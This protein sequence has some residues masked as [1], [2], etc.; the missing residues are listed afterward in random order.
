[1]EVT[2]ETLE[3]LVGDIVHRTMDAVQQCVT[4][5]G[6]APDDIDQVV[7]V[8]GQTRMPLVQ[9]CVTNF[10]KKPPHKGVN[11]DEVVAMGAAIQADILAS[12]DESLLLLDVT[13]LSLGIGTF[14]GQFAS[15][16]P[17]NSTV[18]TRKSHTFTTTRDDQTAVKIRV[19]QGESTQ[20]DE[21]HLLGEFVLTEIPMAE[22]GE[23]E[24][25]VSFEIDSDGIVNVFARDVATEREQSITVNSAGTLSEEEIAQI[26]KENE[27]YELP[28]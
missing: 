13:P 27:E 12:Q 21:N 7:L 2:R 16:I 10:F 11:A 19:L 1:M 26:I 28:Q 3:N 6:L 14:D 5:A 4:D 24:I 15:L 22:A 9:Q 8:G 20:S 18:P 17:R 25:E 23:P